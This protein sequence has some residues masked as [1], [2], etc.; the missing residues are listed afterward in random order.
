MGWTE[1][2]VKEEWS[3]GTGRHCQRMWMGW[4]KAAVSG[5]VVSLISVLHQ[6]P[7]QLFPQ[8][9]PIDAHCPLSAAT[10]QR[11]NW[12]RHRSAEHRQS[13]VTGHTNTH[14]QTHTNTPHSQLTSE[15]FFM[16]THG[17]HAD[18][19]VNDVYPSQTEWTHKH[20]SAGVTTRVAKFP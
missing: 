15:Q 13:G 3:T 10:P 2:S 9:P 6:Q 17:P 5:Q 4:R 14:I 8:L 16:C 18:F 19:L 1:E 12:S 7:P 11:E 20:K